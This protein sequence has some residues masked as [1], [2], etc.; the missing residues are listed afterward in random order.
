MD[1]YIHQQNLI[2]FKKQIAEVNDEV[3]R[4]ML[5]KLLAEEEA[6]EPLPKTG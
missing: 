3:K 5:M 1:E 4:K 2:L 6:K